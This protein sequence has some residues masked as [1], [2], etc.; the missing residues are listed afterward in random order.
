[1]Y[2]CY[3]HDMYLTFLGIANTVM[4]ADIS[5]ILDLQHVPSKINYSWHFMVLYT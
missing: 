4:V 2:T 1:M 3:I 5:F